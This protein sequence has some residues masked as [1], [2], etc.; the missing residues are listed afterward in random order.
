MNVLFIADFPL[1]L[2]NHWSFKIISL[3]DH[4][5]SNFLFNIS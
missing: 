5:I 1:K 3:F 4:K 2:F